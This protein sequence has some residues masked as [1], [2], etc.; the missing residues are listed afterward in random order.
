MSTPPPVAPTPA[1]PVDGVESVEA[2]A[3]KQAFLRGAGIEAE[4]ISAALTPELMELLGKL[5]SHS[6]QG[7]IDLLALRSLVKQEANADVTMVLVRNNNPL[8]FFRDSQTVLTQM[9]RKKMPGFMEPLESV[10]DAWHDLRGHQK[11]VVAGTRAAMQA[12]IE[13]LE[14]ARFAAALPAP[15]LLDKLAPSRRAAGLWQSYAQEH[16]ALAA[17]SQDQFKTLFGPAFLAAYEQEVE[18]FNEAARHG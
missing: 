16:A 5:M 14:P 12:V 9:L 2:L 18:R 3:L 13:R 4:T 8:K 1:A 11:G 6:L 17:D 10:D 7:A 15:G